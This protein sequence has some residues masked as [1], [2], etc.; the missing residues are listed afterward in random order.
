MPRSQRLVF[1]AAS[2]A[3]LLAALVILRPTAKD[4][5]SPRSETP[6]L[7]TTKVTKLRVARGD[8]VRFAV[9]SATPEEIHI[10]GYD[11]MRDAPA[12]KTVRVRFTADIEGIF[13]IEFERA[14]RQLAELRVDP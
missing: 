9:R 3:V 1:I 11:L 14:G 2:V 10:H 8:T 13:E 4:D 6:L 5:P 12:G 7:D